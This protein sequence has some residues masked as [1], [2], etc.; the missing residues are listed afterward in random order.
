MTPNQVQLVQSTLPQLVAMKE[1][2]ARLFYFRL[3]QL[4]PALRTLFKTDLGVQG[5]KLMAILGTL[6]AGLSRPEQ[7]A[8]ILRD[9]GSRHAGYGVQDRD[10]AT[11]GTALLWTLERGLGDAFTA[12]MRDA[13]I[14]T[15][16]LVSRAMMEG[17]KAAAT[18]MQKA[19]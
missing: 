18:P 16:F 19:S 4:D 15:Y 11:V 1:E 2:V 5:H 10:Y 9:L 8:P 13:W 12:E 7:V 14:A 3:F 6:I 17:G